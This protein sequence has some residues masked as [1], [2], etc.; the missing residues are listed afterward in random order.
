M[1]VAQLVAAGTPRRSVA[2]K[3]GVHVFDDFIIYNG[4]CRGA[5][6]RQLIR[7]NWRRLARREAVA[8]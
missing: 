7:G 6:I 4:P 8:P 3:P 5:L 2:A 1:T